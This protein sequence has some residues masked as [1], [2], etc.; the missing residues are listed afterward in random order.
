MHAHT[1]SCNFENW[2]HTACVQTHPRAK[3]RIEKLNT[4][5]LLHTQKKRKMVIKNFFITNVKVIDFSLLILC[6]MT[7]PRDKFGLKW[8]S[9]KT[10]EVRKMRC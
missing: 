6:Y 8:L 9:V 4:K 3:H 5:K 7:S 1:R 10:C 2:I